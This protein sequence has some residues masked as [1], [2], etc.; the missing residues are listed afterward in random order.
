MRGWLHGSI[1]AIVVCFSAASFRAGIE[2][3]RGVG[4]EYS[5]ARGVGRVSRKE[6]QTIL[7]NSSPTTHT[8][9]EAP[10]KRK[11]GDEPQAAEA[12][13]K[14]KEEATKKT[15]ETEKTEETEETK[16]DASSSSSGN[17]TTP[18]SG[19]GTTK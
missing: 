4:P 3:G 6:F 17:K 7:Q 14:T 2:A 9:S 15:K 19:C 16:E 8:M 12:A 11:A 5:I 1:F 13:K 18:C 10:P